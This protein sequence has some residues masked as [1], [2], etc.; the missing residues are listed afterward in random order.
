M[1]GMFLPK[2]LIFLLSWR[3]TNSSVRNSLLF[4]NSPRRIYGCGSDEA[5]TNK[6]DKKYSNFSPVQSKWYIIGVGFFIIKKVAINFNTSKM[7]NNK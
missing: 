3:E 1:G 5:I 6:K 7:K 2:N 4:F